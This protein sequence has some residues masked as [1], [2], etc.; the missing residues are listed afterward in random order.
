M[1]I[2]ASRDKDG[3]F[4]LEI[5]IVTFAL[6]EETVEGLYKVIDQRLNRDDDVEEQNLKRKLDAYRVLATKMSLVDDLVVQKFA[7]QV[8][9][10]QLV[11]I[12]RLSDGQALYQKVLKNLS[13][14]NRRQFQEDFTSLDKITEHNACI[15]ME[16]IVPLIRRAAQEQKALQ[17]QG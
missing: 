4:H 10:E 17:A 14:Q 11:T 5:G 6:T 2:S 1:D 16:Q 7:P 8:T 12:V 9:P 13:K 3:N 15:Y